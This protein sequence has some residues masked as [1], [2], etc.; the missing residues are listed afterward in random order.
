MSPPCAMSGKTEF[1]VRPYHVSSGARSP[2]FG[3]AGFTVYSRLPVIGQPVS[4]IAANIRR[5]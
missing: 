5:I 2:W 3:M 1:R 4:R